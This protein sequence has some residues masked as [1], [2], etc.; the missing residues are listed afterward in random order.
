LC[1]V[2]ANA[3]LDGSYTANNTLDIALLAGVRT[4]TGT[5]SMGT[6]LPD[7]EL[8]DLESV[9]AIFLRGDVIRLPAL[10]VV[11]GT[12]SFGQCHHLEASVLDSV[13]GT[14]GASDAQDGG[15]VLD[16]LDLP[17]L[18]TIDGD[19]IVSTQVVHVRLPALERVTNV[20]P[21]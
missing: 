11:G 6:R 5:L 13:G 19:L 9:G 15:P 17:W 21:F 18:R 10:R 12:A 8:P 20:Q 2:A 4:I 14:L 3:T 1:T 7:V 16:V